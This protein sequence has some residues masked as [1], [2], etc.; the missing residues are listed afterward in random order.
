MKK[1][2]AIVALAVGCFGLSALAQDQDATDALQMSNTEL[3]GTARFQSMAGA[4]GAL[5]GDMTVLTQNP[6][7]IGVYRSSDVGVTFGLDFFSN[8]AAS[9]DK[10]T[11][12]KFGCYNLGYIG[13]I[14]LNSETM[15]NLNFGFTFT[16]RN[17]FRRHFSGGYTGLG[18]SIT[19]YIATE[20]NERGLTANDIYNGNAIEMADVSFDMPT[21]DQNNNSNDGSASAITYDNSNKWYGLT[22]AGPSSAMPYVENA[23]EVETK[24]HT[25]EYNIAF[26][27]N[28]KNKLYW[29]FDIGIID[30]DYD[31]Y[32]YYGEY[33][34]NAVLQYVDKDN[35]V[36]FDNDGTY[37]NIGYHNYLHTDGMGVNLK[38]GVIYKPINEL[39]FGLAVHTPTYYDMRDYYNLTAG[40]EGGYLNEGE[41]FYGE[42]STNDG[43]DT[44]ID[45]TMQTPWRFLGSVAGVLGRSAILSFDYE[46]VGNQQLRVGDE[47][48][49]NYADVTDRAKAYMSPSHIFRLGAEY[50]LSPNWSIRAGY[51]YKTSQVKSEVDDGGDVWS[52][53]MVN[54]SYT[55]DNSL[56]YITAGLGYHYKSFYADLAYVNKMRKSVYA[57][58]NRAYADFSDE[59]KD[60]NNR[61]A[62]TL[63]FRFW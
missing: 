44:R 51:S 18:G 39:R 20:M 53:Y 17:N 30:L 11:T 37:A 47:D 3:S 43:F 57:P 14:K 35:N 59:V 6:G 5:G 55:Y 2:I 4:F 48:G 27:G 10:Y 41:V 61:V 16:R 60:T 1:K 50:R 21:Y 15:P 33:V 13:A 45:Y 49:D 40:L 31:S 22:Q 8:K 46:Y 56:Q 19:D 28:I 32:N 7:G 62:L 58:F 38:F 25:D 23:F 26:G 12:T 9:G 63:G 52:Y 24:G 36:L 54:P 34:E 29:G 42:M